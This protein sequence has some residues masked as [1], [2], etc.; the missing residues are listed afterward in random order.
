MSTSA[1]KAPTQS[2]AVLRVRPS[3]AAPSRMIGSRKRSK[4]RLKPQADSSRTMSTMLP[5]S[6]AAS[7]VT[8]ITEWCTTPPQTVQDPRNSAGHRRVPPSS[9][10]ATP[11]PT[12]SHGAAT[13]MT[14]KL[15]SDVF[16]RTRSCR[17]PSRRRR[18]TVQR[19]P[20]T[21]S[22]SAAIAANSGCSTAYSIAL[23]GVS[24]RSRD[25]SRLDTV[26]AH[27][28]AS[29]PGD[30]IPQVSGMLRRF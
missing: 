5:A 14:R 11:I 23:Y 8:E 20:P 19:R 22:A 17:P 12:A 7:T 28:L 16:A 2:I 27:T 3:T 1:A 30:R 25:K 24:E 18:E 6:A 15:G 4:D 21:A 13:D 26:V 10:P 9:S 29:G